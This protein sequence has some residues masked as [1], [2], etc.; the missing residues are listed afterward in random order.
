[1]QVGGV[2]EDVR[3][4]GVGRKTVTAFLISMPSIPVSKRRIAALEHYSDKSHV[5][6]E[7]GGS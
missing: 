1:M 4:F 2:G 3:P 7:F 6:Y 5:D